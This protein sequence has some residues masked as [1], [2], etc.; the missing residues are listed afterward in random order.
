MKRTIILATALFLIGCVSGPTVHR[1]IEAYEM[2]R[3]GASFNQWYMQHLRDKQM[4]RIER[5]LKGM[6]FYQNQDRWNKSMEP[7]LRQKPGYNPAF[8][9]GIP[10]T[11][12]RW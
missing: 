1:S 7:Y 5:R 3:D 12:R 8:I 6:E 4:D 11:P 2:G 9:P 10:Y